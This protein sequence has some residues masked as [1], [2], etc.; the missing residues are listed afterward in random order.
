MTGVSNATPF[1]APHECVVSGSRVGDLSI[2]RFAWR[3]Q[4]SEF[5]DVAVEGYVAGDAPISDNRFGPADDP[6]KSLAH[7]VFFASVG[8][9]FGREGKPRLCGG[10]ESV[11]PHYF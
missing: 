11:G 4:I 10:G 1:V 2:A 6:L 5:G 3:E 9:F 7:R 8:G